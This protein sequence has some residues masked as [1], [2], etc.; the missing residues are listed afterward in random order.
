MDGQRFDNLTRSLVTPAS[1]REVLRLVAGGAAGGLLAVLGAGRTRA[2]CKNDDPNCMD[3]KCKDAGHVCNA[4]D[5][6]CGGLVCEGG[7]CVP[8]CRIDGGYYTPETPALDAPC[9]LCRPAASTT[10]WTANADA[11]CD[12]GDVCSV[13]DACQADGSCAGVPVDCTSF[14]GDCVVGACDPVTGACYATNRPDQTPCIGGDACYST[15]ACQTGVCVGSDPVVCQPSDACH[16]AGACDPA[17][18]ACSNPPAAAGVG[19]G[20]AAWCRDGVARAAD[21]CD[22]SGACVLGTE[23]ACFPYLC[24]GDACGTSCAADADCAPAAHCDDNSQCRSDHPLGGACDGPGDCESGYC[25]RGVCC[26]V[27][28]EGECQACTAETGGVCSPTSGQACTTGDACTPGV[29]QV[30]VCTPEDSVVCPDCQVCD[31]GSGSC[32]ADPAQAG[33]LCNQPFGGASMCGR[34]QADGTCSG[35]IIVCASLDG[36]KSGGCDRTTGRCAT[37]NAPNG[38]PCTG[39]LDSCGTGPSTCQ[40]GTCVSAEYVECSGYTDDCGMRVCDGQGGCEV[41]P[42]VAPDGTPCSSND[43]CVGP[44][45]FCLSG[46]CVGNPSVF[47]P[48]NPC[49]TVEMCENGMG[50]YP[51]AYQPYGTEV[52]PDSPCVETSICN[53]AGGRINTLKPE[54]TPIPG[55]EC[56]FCDENGGIKLMPGGPCDDG[57][58]CTTDDYCTAEGTCDGGFRIMRGL[59][60]VC[61]TS[62][63]TVEHPGCCAAGLECRLIPGDPGHVWYCLNS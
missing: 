7:A 48:Y 4:D 56:R 2:M 59:F 60:E 23:T 53:G 22:G 24:S 12:D 20:E 18:G 51:I 11:A 36:C 26:N 3:D 35:G 45:E 8:G 61:N 58:V 54:D 40:A 38:T 25:V 19:C 41:V 52:E 6:C 5:R 13:N 63:G 1:R 46:H 39:P 30:G 21:L 50:C 31:P 37:V 14:D 17:T 43:P 49:W 47:C 62:F 16:A 55:H 9:L 28:C 32:V 15:Y 42:G 29:C 33:S 27:P 57:D 44:D 34:C 10:S